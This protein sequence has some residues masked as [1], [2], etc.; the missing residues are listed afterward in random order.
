MK[1][2]LSNYRVGDFVQLE[3][4]LMP[5]FKITDVCRFTGTIECYSKHTGLTSLYKFTSLKPNAYIAEQ[6]K[7]DYI[8]GGAW[9]AN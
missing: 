2:L 3:Y 5:V 6:A 1:R 7:T 9:Y 4:G 8:L